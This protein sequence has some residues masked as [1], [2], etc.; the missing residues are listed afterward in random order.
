[1]KSRI[2][3]VNRIDQS[4]NFS[5]Q[6]GYVQNG[7]LPIVAI[8]RMEHLKQRLVKQLS[9]EYAEV[10]T[11]L[12]HQAVNEAS[13]LAALTPVPFLVLPSLAEEKVQQAADWS[14]RQRGLLGGTHQAFAA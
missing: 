9:A 6:N 13:A 14:V 3:I 11:R 8:T 1:M 5:A 2:N 7:I 4:V 10:E 12:L